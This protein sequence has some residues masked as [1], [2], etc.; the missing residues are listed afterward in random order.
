L[1]LRRILPGGIFLYRK[2]DPEAYRNKQH[3]AEKETR[4]RAEGT[5]LHTIIVPYTVGID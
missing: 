1:L 4:K 2:G 3:K 5:G